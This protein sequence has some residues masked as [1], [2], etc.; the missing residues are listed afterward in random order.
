MAYLAALFTIGFLS[1][2]AVMHLL[3]VFI[4]EA[5]KDDSHRWLMKILATAMMVFGVL[6]L[7]HGF[8]AS[9]RTESSRSLVTVK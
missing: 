2:S 8:R 1:A 3:G 4:G 7:I 5:F 9:P 6:F